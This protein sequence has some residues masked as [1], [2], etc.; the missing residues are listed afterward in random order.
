M[1]KITKETRDKI[2][3]EYDLEFLTPEA[4]GTN[5]D[6][7]GWLLKTL[8]HLTIQ[9]S[10]MRKY[11]TEPKNSSDSPKIERD[12]LVIGG[13]GILLTDG[14]RYIPVTVQREKDGGITIKY[15]KYPL[16]Q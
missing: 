10:E 14:C 2:L 3:K 12:W 7:R 9:E 11:I 16:N 15:R 1:D 6:I 8:N 13:E 4:I 5:R